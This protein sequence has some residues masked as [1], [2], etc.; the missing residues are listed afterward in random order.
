MKYNKYMK[1][2]KQRLFEMM[3]LVDSSFY[4]D[5]ENGNPEFHTDMSEENV[6]EDVNRSYKDKYTDKVY[7]A[8]QVNDW[9][10]RYKDNKNFT[11]T[12]KKSYRQFFNHI[13]LSQ[14]KYET[15]KKPKIQLTK[16]ADGVGYTGRGFFDNYMVDILITSNNNNT[17]WYFKW[18]INRNFV[19][20]ESSKTFKL[21]NNNLDG[22]ALNR[23]ADYKKKLLFLKEIINEE[24]K[25]LNL[26]EQQN[27][28]IFAKRG[29]IKVGFTTSST[30]DRTYVTP[31]ITIE[32]SLI[33]PTSIDS[34]KFTYKNRVSIS[35]TDG[36]VSRFYE[37]IRL[38]A[39]GKYLCNVSFN[40]K[41]VS[42]NKLK[43]IST[44]VLVFNKEDEKNPIDVINISKYI[45]E[46]HDENGYIILDN[47]VTR[48]YKSGA[49]KTKDDASF[50]KG[51]KQ[52]FRQGGKDLNKVTDEYFNKWEDR[53][54]QVGKYKGSKYGELIKKDKRY[55]DWFLQNTVY[56]E[57]SP[58]TKYDIPTKFN[59]QLYEFLKNNG[60]L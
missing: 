2:N 53:F 36:R 8:D 34:N 59:N 15:Y 7:S 33:D 30:I 5:Y 23:I 48:I 42:I 26:E 24:L 20:S 1:Y 45:F 6:I 28:I 57:P 21:T 51:G 50:S 35:D 3:G 11:E 58:E 40:F 47:D 46:N 55:F 14:D 31:S 17:E 56:Y 41:K 4:Y 49:I 52:I 44:D 60:L 10:H 25:A 37:Y 19:G 38:T 39:G 18:F 54:V 12:Q 16:N 43:D 32:N 27:D 29:K 22:N 9:I 13:G